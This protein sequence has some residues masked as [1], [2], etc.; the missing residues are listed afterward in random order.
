M[1]TKRIHHPI[2]VARLAAVL[3][4][5]AAAVTLTT[6]AAATPDTAK[7]RAITQKVVVGPSIFAKLEASRLVKG[8]PVTASGTFTATQ[9]TIGP[10]LAPHC[11]PPPQTCVIGRPLDKGTITSTF[12]LVGKP[13]FHDVRAT[14][15]GTATARGKRGSVTWTFSAPAGAIVGASFPRQGPGAGHGPVTIFVGTGK[16]LITDA[17]RDLAELKGRTALTSFYFNELTGALLVSAL[18]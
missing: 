4:A 7:Q 1:P 17:T 10:S 6:V 14:V 13:S 12:T 8:K 3:V 18:L 5:L 2:A 15:R 11:A 9:W 16:A